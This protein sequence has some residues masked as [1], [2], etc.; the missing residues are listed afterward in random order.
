MQREGVVKQLTNKALTGNIQATR[1]YLD[2]YRQAHE[3]VAL[4]AVTQSSDSRKYRAED[5]TEDQLTEIILRGE[6]ERKM[7]CMSNVLNTE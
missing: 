2:H 1:I 3:R 4:V 7:L 5:L 6:E